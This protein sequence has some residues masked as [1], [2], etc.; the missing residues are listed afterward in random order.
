M[1]E[2]KRQDRQKLQLYQIVAQDTSLT[3]LALPTHSIYKNEF[4]MS[5]SLMMNKLQQSISSLQDKQSSLL[6]DQKLHR[7]FSVATQFYDESS[8][9]NHI[10]ANEKMIVNLMQCMI[11]CG[12]GECHQFL[13]SK[14]AETYVHI[15][16]KFKFKSNALIYLLSLLTSNIDSVISSS[17]KQLAK[18][19]G[20]AKHIVVL[21][22]LKD[23]DSRSDGDQLS[24]GKNQNAGSA[25]FDQNLRSSK[26]NNSAHMN[27]E[28]LKARNV[29]HLPPVS[30]NLSNHFARRS[31]ST[32][33]YSNRSVAHHL[34]QQNTGEFGI[35]QEPYVHY[36]DQLETARS[37]SITKRSQGPQNWYQGKLFDLE[38]ASQEEYQFYLRFI[39]QRIKTIRN[40]FD[41]Y[42]SEPVSQASFRTF[43]QSLKA[44]KVLNIKDVNKFLQDY[45]F[46][47]Q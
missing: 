23:S 31:R 8:L 38:S 19:G 37:N 27:L 17:R 6:N 40:I 20:K 42:S 26:A 4:N 32:Q 45:N 34:N 30:V 25:L 35:K 18:H 14:L 13:T 33:L 29:G 5:D 28:S 21:S 7:M 41:A 22:S 43:E 9:Y 1:S 12:D 15:E 10:R 11:M 46:N 36:E 44:E 24:V 47:K 2:I 3:K 39:Q 16:Q